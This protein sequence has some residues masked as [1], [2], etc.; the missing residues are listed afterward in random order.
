LWKD[1]LGLHYGQQ[2]FKG[3]VIRIFQQI[4][5]SASQGA[6]C[7]ASGAGMIANFTIQLL[8]PLTPAGYIAT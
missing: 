3:A 1:I 4:F 2:I 8:Y 7:I 5:G 6:W